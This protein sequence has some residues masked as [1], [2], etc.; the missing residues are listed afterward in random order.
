MNHAA[1]KVDSA[2]KLLTAGKAA[3]GLAILTALGP[4]AAQ[5]VNACLVASQCY[6][7]LRDY[8]RALF[9]AQRASF[10][11]PND[12]Q[13]L[14]VLVTAL[15][16]NKKFKESTAAL[17]KIIQLAPKHLE[18]RLQLASEALGNGQAGEA[19]A[20]FEAIK[21]EPWTANHYAQYA[22]VL[23]SLCRPNEAVAV[24]TQAATRF[25]TSDSV[26]DALCMHSNYADDAPIS[27]VA[28]AH[29]K[30]GQL[31]TRY[32]PPHHF[33]HTGTRDP[34]RKLRVGFLSGDFRTHSVAFFIESLF[35]FLPRSE[36]DIVAYSL[37]RHPD[38]MTEKFKARAT[39]WR[40]CPEDIDVEI[41]R[42]VEQD[43][44]DILIDL[45][46]HTSGGELTVF[47]Y[48]P[49]PI[50]ITYCG[51]PNTTGLSEINYRIVDSHTDP[52]ASNWSPPLNEPDAPDFDARCSERLWRLDPCFL[53]YTPSTTNLPKPS[54]LTRDHITFGSF[55]ASRKITRSTLSLWASVLHAV[56]NS[57]LLLKSMEFSSPLVT[58]YVRDGLAAHNVELSRLTIAEPTKSIA[59][60]LDVYNSVDVALDTF[61]YHGTTTTCEALMM[62][63]PVIT[64]AGHTHAA[65]VG[66]SL[67]HAIGCPELIASSPENFVT[68][69]AQLAGDSPRLQTL[70]SAL[71][72]RTLDSPL[73]DS[74]GFASRFMLALRQMWQQHCAS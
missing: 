66:V 33:Q 43:A 12:T 29:R 63:V 38:A 35:E 58:A 49:A 8:P 11:Q 30:Y 51:Y 4:K 3:E 15:A 19:L 22:S 17:Q 16:A 2:F 47:S 72:Q 31:L 68:I 5:D 64:L 71:R 57:R 62:G 21:G 60:H 42:K 34:N 59:A 52:Q 32:R 40:D 27:L 44:V 18:A 41:A 67:L 13:V 50:Q 53:C 26:L 48:K 70:H 7:Q 65:R 36:C 55:N 39:L 45:A 73:C 23:S 10:L 54:T 6:I 14:T 1:Q 20:H 69:A 37:T 61:P 25:P 24:L 28:E 46:G 74:R 56:P 9:Q